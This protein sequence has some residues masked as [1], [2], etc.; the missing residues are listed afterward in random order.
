MKGVQPQK[1]IEHRAQAWKLFNVAVLLHIENE[2]GC[3]NDDLV[4]FESEQSG[5]YH[6]VINRSTGLLKHVWKNSDIVTKN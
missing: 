1:S 3:L 2:Q 5:N 6:F 4:L